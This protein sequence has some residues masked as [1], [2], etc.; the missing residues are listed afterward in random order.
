MLRISSPYMKYLTQDPRAEDWQ[1]YCTDTGYTEVAPFERYP[2]R[3]KSHPPDYSFNLTTGRVLRE[4][5]VVYITRGNGYFKSV[6]Q[7]L[8]SIAPG[9]AFLLFPGVWH[10]YCPVREKGWDEYWVGFK[11]EYPDTLVRKGFFS[12]SE[13]VFHLG[14]SESIIHDFHSIFEL[15][16]DESPGFQYALGAMV[17]Q[18]LSKMLRITL[19]SAHTTEEE[20]IIQVTKC[21]FEESLYGS[22]DLQRLLRQV[23][24]N[25]PGLRTLFKRYTGLTPYHYYLQMK[26]NKAKELL[27]EGQSSVKEIAYKLGF[28][29]EAYFSRFF[30]N[31]T[32]SSPTAWQ[33]G[34]HLQQQEQAGEENEGGVGS[35]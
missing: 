5:Q 10:S 16:G 30:K 35:S 31:K 26:T 4:Y 1:I 25:E 22:L 14:L 13:P 18:L 21:H 27:M 9:T 33:A 19:K 34:G 23:G 6:N 8:H 32:G 7:Q 3:V 24:M 20:R 12:P 29:S 17:L 2:P 11:G 15:A 28:E